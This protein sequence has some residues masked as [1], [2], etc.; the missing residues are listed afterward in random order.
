MSDPDLR[1]GPAP[2]GGRYPLALDLTGRTV[3]IVGGG[4]VAA[5]RAR[6]LVDASARVTVIAPS[7]CDELA[8]L[9]SRAAPEQDPPVRWKRREYRGPSD[10]DG[11]WLVHTA[12]GN[13]QV[14]A[15][16]GEDC[17]ARRLWCVDA[18]DA[19]RSRAWV[20]ATTTVGTPAGPV[21]VSVTSGGDPRRAVAIRDALT[22]ELRS[23]RIDLRRRRPRGAG[24]VALVGGGP[25][26]DGLVTTRGRTLL[27]AADVVVVDR[28]APRGI[29]AAL[30][31]GVQVIDAG[32]S[33]RRHAVPQHRINE[34]LVE[35]AR[36]GRGVV[37]LKGGDPFVLG[38][39]GEEVQACAAAGVR[40]EVVPGVTSAVAVPAAAGIPVTHRGLARGFSVATGHDQLPQLP[41]GNDH[42]VLL[43]MAV[44]GL[45]RC[46]AAMIA[47]GRAPDCPAA[48]IEDGFGPA[49][50][51]T[52]APLARL[53]QEAQAAG[54][55]SPAVV[56]VGDVVTLCPA[57]RDRRGTP[58][59]ALGAR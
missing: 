19:A 31:A 8:D 18:G 42:T 5:R 48:I 53:A 9:T 28:L 11:A 46:V 21:D 41:T 3:V 43:L 52:V 24:W 14:D 50:R 27:A 25:G 30:P 38:R 17:R 10:L 44:R 58:A 13:P 49:Q 59:A 23:G 54:V 35:H 57:W 15:A 36:A 45:R 39:G 7:I 2:G 12:T 22:G 26:D 20:P 55:R 40:V 16:V 51:V 4:P 6:G 47:A 1:P 29:L 34:L 56:V 37:R 33:P 32:K